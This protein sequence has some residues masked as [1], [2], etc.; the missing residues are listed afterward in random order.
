MNKKMEEVLSLKKQKVP[1][2][3]VVK[4]T[5]ALI[6]SLSPTGL[7]SRL[8]AVFELIASAFSIKC[9][10]SDCGMAASILDKVALFE[11]EPK[12]AIRRLSLWYEGVR[13]LE[14]N[15]LSTIATIGER[16]GEENAKNVVQLTSAVGAEIRATML[17]DSDYLV[18]LE[19]CKIECCEGLEQ[20]T[21]KPLQILEIISCKT[22]NLHECEEIGDL[23]SKVSTR[24]DFWSTKRNQ[25]EIS[26]P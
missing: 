9:L 13:N 17:N 3:K 26:L 6:G 11:I 16:C 4:S 19:K 10:V 25:K 23:V 7:D 1:D 8:D 20:A 2:F 24:V 14:R 18:K 21:F 5:L 12:D 22:K 15:F